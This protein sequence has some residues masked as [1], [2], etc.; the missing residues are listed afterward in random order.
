MGE[1]LSSWL[2]FGKGSAPLFP[3]GETPIPRFL[4]KE[5]DTAARIHWGKSAQHS[6]W[7][8]A[9]DPVL[10][11]TTALI[12]WAS[13]SGQEP[14]KGPAC[15]QGPWEGDTVSLLLLQIRKAGHGTHAELTGKD[16]AAGKD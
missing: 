4:G 1:S 3:N 11:R 5:R 15:C 2:G 12:C 9:P 16:P 13:T 7:H 10:L 6:P 8:A 14:H